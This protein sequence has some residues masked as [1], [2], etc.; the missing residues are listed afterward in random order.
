M[1]TVLIVLGMDLLGVY[2]A[3]TW[4]YG[5]CY[6][7]EHWQGYWGSCTLAWHGFMRALVWPVWLALALV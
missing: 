7:W 1:T 5:T 4:V 2:I 3:G 6:V